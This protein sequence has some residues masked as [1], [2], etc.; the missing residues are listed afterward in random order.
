MKSPKYILGSLKEK[1]GTTEE[2]EQEGFPDMNYRVGNTSGLA[3]GNIPGP[4]DRRV[5]DQ[6]QIGGGIMEVQIYN[7]A[8]FSLEGEALMKSINQLGIDITLHSNPSLGYTSAY[9]T[10]GQ[11]VG[12][13]TTQE[14]FT[15]YLQELAKWKRE[16]ETR[17]SMDF[18]IGR[19]N[20]HASTSPL[21]AL[22]QRAAADV[23][24]DPFG[25]SMTALEKDNW[26]YRNNERKNIFRNEEFLKQFYYTFIKKRTV[27]Q[28]WRLYIGRQGVFSNYS[29]KLDRIFR[30]AQREAC[31]DFYEQELEEVGD[32]LR[33]RVAL[34]STAGRADVGVQDQWLNQIREPFDDDEQ[35]TLEGTD[36]RSQQMLEEL[37]L[38][39]IVSLDDVN[40]FLPPNTRVTRLATLSEAVYRIENE[41]FEP[42]REIRQLIQGQNTPYDS[43]SDIIEDWDQKREDIKKQA[44][45]SIDE[46][47]DNLWYGETEEGKPLISAQGKLQAVA[48][49]LD[50]EQQRIFE[51]TLD[52]EG[53]DPE[54]DESP[55]ELDE[56]VEKVISGTKEFFED[57]N[58]EED[59]DWK[60]RYRKMLNTLV[61]NFEQLIWQ[62]SNLFYY[63]LPAWMSSSSESNENHEGW[64]AP[65]FIWESI[66]ERN[67]DEEYVDND[68][69]SYD[70]DLTNP[71][72]ENGYF[73]ALE[74][75]REFQ[76]D[77]AAAVGACYIWTHFTQIKESFDTEDSRLDLTDKEKEQIKEEGWTWA[78]WMNKFGIGV[79]IESMH[80]NPQQLL[81]VWRPKD[82]VVAAR[83][84]N[85]TARNRLKEEGGTLGGREDI[86][87]QLDGCIA[88]FTI[89][90]EHVA[91]FGVNPWEEMKTL[92]EQEK[93]LAKNTNYD[94]EA[95]EDKPIAKM[96]RQYHLM[97]PGLEEQQGTRHGPFARGDE[98]LY[99]WLYRLVEAGFA[100]N[101]EEAAAIMYEQ[102]E[103]KAETTYVTRI[104]MNMIELGI[105]PQ[106][107]DP[108]KVDPRK[109]EYDD[110]KEALMAR[111][112]GM[113]K[114]SYD[115]EWAK[116]EEHAFDPLDGLLEA[117]QFD[118][119]W[120]GRAAIKRDKLREWS[121]EE[122]K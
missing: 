106:E 84:I 61:G 37:D 3:V 18:H 9:K 114:T 32:P 40:E 29:P 115:R 108:S 100:R 24:L 4:L 81:K 27:D 48:N 66:V 8:S 105:D 17:E 77:V 14:Y 52:K 56:A 30:D 21:P 45:A 54:T 76:L 118:H 91:S 120:S 74:N 75:E 112:F 25:F 22:E 34:V 79:N 121:Q 57:P 94:I 89:D 96:L 63:I 39:T 113:D 50:V 13:E 92:I 101:P 85:I 80:G 43:L 83:A 95:D 117:P 28:L 7:P 44:L 20:P 2:E 1:F 19:I 97:K 104:T 23:A 16:V 72:K 46:K 68:Q 98:Q 33:S 47:L 67:W 65:E 42:S 122:Y 5:G 26:D 64:E 11:A 103:E 38:D 59:D 58:G 70:L 86:H 109:D 73:E 6:A 107:L 53:S 12:F 119:T 41:D 116:I 102:G 35:I 36:N 88:K 110:E 111:F 49:H 60:E 82:I 31:D 90:M 69:K 78:D 71:D 93:H 15:N 99:T 51:E 55:W 10:G 87:P 62:E